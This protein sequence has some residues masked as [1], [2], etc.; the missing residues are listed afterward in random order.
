MDA[1]AVLAAADGGGR[2]GARRRAARRSWNAVTYRF[3]GHHTA[4]RTMKLGYRTDE[5]IERWRRRDPLDVHGA[6]ARPATRASGSTREVEALLDEARRASPARARGPT[7]P[8]RSTSST[9]AACAPA[10][11]SR[12]MTSLRY[13]QALGTGA[14]RRDGARPDGVRGRRGRARVAARRHEGP[15]SATS[16]PTASSTCRS[17]SRCSRASR[18]ARRSPAS[19]PVVEY[20]IPALLYLAFEQIANQAQKLRLMT[21]GQA[22][23]ARRLPRARAPAR[24]SGCAAQHSDHPYSLFAHAA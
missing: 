19:A 4:E 9:R 5:E 24:A 17:P 20:Q 10:A 8:R 18:P 11:R 13:L 23:G 1:E 14:A 15:G 22:V 16:A 12:R 3:F 6:R 21:G 2:A 7:R